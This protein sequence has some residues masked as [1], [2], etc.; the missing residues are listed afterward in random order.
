MYSRK[1]KKIFNRVRTKDIVYVLDR[2]D[3]DLPPTLKVIKISGKI[4]VDYG[5]YEEYYLYY[6]SNYRFRLDLLR[7]E[8]YTSRKRANKAYLQAYRQHIKKSI[9]QLSKL[10]EWAK[11]LER[12]IPAKKASLVRMEKKYR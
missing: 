11:N 8:V 3:Y 7:D 9:Q 5:A 6:G 2:H 1:Y 12:R 4:K 10:K